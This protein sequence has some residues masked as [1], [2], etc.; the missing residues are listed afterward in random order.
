[1]RKIKTLNI[2]DEIYTV[3]YLKEVDDCPR[4]Y[5]VCDFD[6]KEIEIRKDISPKGNLRTTIH[7]VLHA[8]C[9]EHKI[10][11]KHADIHKLDAAIADFLTDN[12]SVIKS[13]YNQP[14]Q[15]HSSKSLHQ[16]LHEAFQK[17]ARRCR[18]MIRK[19]RKIFLLR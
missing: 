19:G 18:L 10:R 5:G 13:M 6:S 14:G 4:T 9:D 8:I 1:M 2:K 7:E 11:I 16:R 17:I 15:S 3:K 12:H